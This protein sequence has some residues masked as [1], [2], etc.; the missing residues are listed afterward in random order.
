M[1]HPQKIGSVIVPKRLEEGGFSRNSMRKLPANTAIHCRA[2]MSPPSVRLFAIGASNV[3]FHE[4][5][6]LNN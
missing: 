5:S 1:A 6:L 3:L 2:K 4:T